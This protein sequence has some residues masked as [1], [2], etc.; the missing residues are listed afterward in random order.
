MNWT[1]QAI[2]WHVY[3]LGF[4]GAPIRVEDHGDRPWE[5]V[6][7]PQLMNWLDYAVALGC[8]GILLGPIF[9][10]TSHGYDTTD[11]FKI[12]PR[13]GDN[14]DFDDL[15]AACKERGI[16]ILLDGVFS[17]V[18]SE[19]PLLESALTS[20]EGSKEAALFDVDYSDPANP[21][22]QVWEGHGNLVRFKHSAHETREFVASVMKFW[23][24]KGI[25]G[26]RLDAAYSVPT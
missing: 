8:N 9:Q 13:L 6:R 15:V 11:Y 3:P 16:R 26:W 2:W 17:H 23:L 1:D 20:G 19:N 4:T 5:A 21:K 18:G 12:D 25:D 7:L 14:T 10:S 22:L 24:E